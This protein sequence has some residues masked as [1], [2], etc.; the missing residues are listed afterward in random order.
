M[1]TLAAFAGEAIRKHYEKQEK[2]EQILDAETTEITKV[3]LAKEIKN[4]EI[5]RIRR[6]EDLVYKTTVTEEGKHIILVAEEGCGFFEC[7]IEVVFPPF[8]LIGSRKVCLEVFPTD[9]PKLNGAESGQYW[10][11]TPLL[12]IT[13]PKTLPFLKKVTVRVPLNR[14]ARKSR[15]MSQLQPQLTEA[16][17]PSN[18]T[19]VFVELPRNFIEI[20]STQF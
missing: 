20:E 3:V 15:L 4:K 16:I 17:F 9:D 12:Q 7:V 11:L 18:K 2:V 10:I 8:C 1:S 14:S 5:H 13:H 6:P 19:V